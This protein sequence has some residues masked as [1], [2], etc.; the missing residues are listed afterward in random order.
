M[1][2]QETICKCAAASIHC[3]GMYACVTQKSG[4]VYGKMNIII[5]QQKQ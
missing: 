1:L 3:Y 4:S 5:L 2:K